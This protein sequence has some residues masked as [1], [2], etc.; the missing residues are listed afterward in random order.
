MPT[1]PFPLSGF[2][3]RR[4]GSAVAGAGRIMCRF[5]VSRSG[6]FGHR[7]SC[8]RTTTAALNSKWSEVV[9]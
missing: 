2:L 1:L 5:E 9:E 7:Y 3:A 4:R 6:A 8:R